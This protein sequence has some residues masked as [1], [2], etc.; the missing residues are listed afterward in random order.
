[1]PFS[2]IPTATFGHPGTCGTYTGFPDPYD[3]YDGTQDGIETTTVDE[4][5][6]KRIYNVTTVVTPGIAGSATEIKVTVALASGGPILATETS[7][8]SSVGTATS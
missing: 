3:E 1:M 8:F 2:C 4:S 7:Y 5:P 6:D